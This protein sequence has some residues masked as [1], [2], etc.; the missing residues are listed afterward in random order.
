MADCGFLHLHLDRSGLLLFLGVAGLALGGGSGAFSAQLRGEAV[1]RR[2]RLF[3][4]ARRDQSF[5]QRSDFLADVLL[6][7]RNFTRQMRNL[8]LHDEAQRPEDGE[9]EH[10]DRDDRRHASKK[11]T[12]QAPY[13]RRQYEG[14]QNG[15]GE[16]LEH[17]AA[18]IQ[19][20]KDETDNDK[21]AGHTDDGCPPVPAAVA[22]LTL[23][24]V[25]SSP[26]N[27]V[28]PW[29]QGFFRLEPMCLIGKRR[30]GLS[31]PMGNWGGG[32]FVLQKVFKSA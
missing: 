10:H 31:V 25:P 23:A 8:D 7:F 17:H 22:M 16:R 24:C 20:G 14:E 6:I 1:Q 32:R 4:R 12:A 3:E 27:A 30:R 11:K 2:G 26:C 5:V 28:K 9:G 15:Y 13:R 19:D 21:A 29:L 18:E